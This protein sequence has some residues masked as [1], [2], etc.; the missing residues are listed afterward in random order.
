MVAVGDARGA[1]DLFDVLMT[2]DADGALIGLRLVGERSAIG[3]V[4]RYLAEH[5]LSVR[6]ESG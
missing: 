5:G 4:K 1:E 2:G 6:L 3:E